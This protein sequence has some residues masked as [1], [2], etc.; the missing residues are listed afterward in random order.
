M[1]KIQIDTELFF[2]L[3][4]QRFSKKKLE[5][6]LV[7]AKA[8][9][10]EFEEGSS[11]AK[12]KIELNDTNRP[13]LWSTA[14]LA[15]HLKCY[16]TSTI[17]QFSFYDQPSVQDKTII[18]DSHLQNIRPYVVGLEISGKEI[19]ETLLVELIQS[20]EKLCENFGQKRNTIAMGIYRA[21]DIQ[22]PI[23]YKACDID[24]TEFVPLDF[25]TPLSL[26]KIV[27]T[28][29]K[30][31]EYGHIIKNYDAYPLLV[32]A[33]NEVLSMPPIINSAHLGAVKIGDDHLFIE[34]TGWNLETLFLAVSIC[35][36]DY[37]DL[38]FQITRLS[39]CY[40]YDTGYSKEII[41]PH[42]FQKEK[43]C[44]TYQVSTLLGID[45]TVKEITE[46]LHRMGLI[47]S[48]KDEKTLKVKVPPYRNDFLHSVDIIED[49]MIG[50]GLSKYEPEMPKSFTIGRL[51]VRE[52]TKRN[53][54]QAM[55]GLGFQEMMFP[56]LGSK[57]QHIT[58]IYEESEV[59]E[60]ENTFAKVSNP[61]SENYE[62]VRQSILPNLLETERVSS[63]SMYP[64]K[65]CEVGE[66]VMKD[67]EDNYG[68][69][70]LQ[71]LGF[72]Q[73]DNQ[74]GFT[75]IN[76]IIA[77]LL[78]YYNIDWK[79]KTVYDSRFIEDRVAVVVR[80]IDEAV[81]GIFGEIH[82]RILEQFDITMPCA[83]GELF[84]DKFYET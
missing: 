57:Q 38:G 74:V 66:I 65:I 23:Y 36:C 63:N 34:L 30:G 80:M 40:Q 35:A 2:S 32:D 67:T 43:E 79:T 73:A 16:L 1:P 19:D 46:S 60:K 47:T 13:D 20:Q 15:R 64:H 72:L 49:I 5:D 6:I 84:L 44:N 42:Y 77:A 69:K 11:N 54:L 21:S 39:S 31:K 61:I 3:L 53:V 14:G 76:S 22:W 58:Q 68:F 48:V 75:D 28:H 37:A 55:I 62:Y 27:E 56:Y 82:P 26:R 29:P 24:T 83:G 18:V 78:F 41:S 9:L 81:L 71:V 12:L 25:T 8:E 45:H 52:K 17:P 70:T 10:D 7:V 33:K 51:S 59:A 4:G 50:H